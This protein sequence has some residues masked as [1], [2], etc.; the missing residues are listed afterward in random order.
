M[1]EVNELENKTLLI[2]QKIEHMQK[3]LKEHKNLIEKNEEKIN[4]LENW[5]SKTQGVLITFNIVL[6]IIAVIATGVQAYNS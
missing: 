2:T 3:E 6:G 5:R 4:E 1:S